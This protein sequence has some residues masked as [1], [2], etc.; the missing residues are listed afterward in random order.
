MEPLPLIVII[1]YQ[2]EHWEII[3]MVWDHTIHQELIKMVYSS[4][5]SIFATWVMDGIDVF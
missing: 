2:Q 3:L 5:T 4:Y 1:I